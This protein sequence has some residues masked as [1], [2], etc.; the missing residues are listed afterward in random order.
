MAMLEPHEYLRQVPL[1]SRLSD[2]NL[3]RVASIAHIETFPRAS[4]LASIGQPGRAFYYIVSGQAVVHAMVDRRRVRP[5]AYLRPGQHFGV[6]SLLLGEP[7]DATVEAVTD[8]AALVIDRAEFQRIRREHPALNDQ[9]TL[10]GEVDVKLRQSR[11]PWLGPGEVL[12][13]VGRRHWYVLARAL[14]LPTLGVLLLAGL[15]LL[16]LRTLHAWWGIALVVSLIFYLPLL[17]WHLVDWRNDYL[18]VTTERVVHREL[19]VLLYESRNEAPLDRIQD[20]TV[21]R[22]LWGQLLGFGH[23]VVQTAARASVSPVAFDHLPDPDRAKNIIF[24]QIYR[25]R[26]RS[27]SLAREAMRRELRR[28]LGWSTADELRAQHEEQPATADGRPVQEPGGWLASLR[29]LR[30]IPPTR[31]QEGNR[32]TWRKHWLFLLLRV[33]KPLLLTALWSLLLALYLLGRIPVLGAPPSLGVVLGWIV[34]GLPI[35]FWFWWQAVDWSNDVYILTD[36]RI[37]DVEKKPLFFAEERREA[38]LD[39]VQNVTLAVPGPLAALLN[40]GNVDIDTAGGEGKFT[41]TRVPAPRQVQQEIMARVAGHQER[42]QQAESAR[43]RKEITDWFA[44]YEK[45]RQER[46]GQERPPSSSPAFPPP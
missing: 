3:R 13:F 36:D 19:V 22:D 41:F 26:G 42:R 11:L 34:I 31:I 10:P 23:V 14:L 6:T 33:G 28:Q 15:L 24:Q 37:I 4:R 21:K 5:V 8:M 32:I 25:V 27:T 20:V 9:L 35:A 17:V 18:A 46:Q 12:V 16:F 44:V 38:T 43:R 1:F 30:L 2:A 29:G 39:R 7:H 40:Y 45:L